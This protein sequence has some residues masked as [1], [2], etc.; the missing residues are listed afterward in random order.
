MLEKLR[1]VEERYLS[2]EG[3][4]ADPE[5][6][7]DWQKYSKLAKERSDLEPI[8]DKYRELLKLEEEAAE[9]RRLLADGDADLRQLAQE[10]I[11]DLEP[12]IAELERELKV[13]LVPRD[14]NDEKNIILEIRAG[15]G[16]EEA[17]LFGADLFRMYTKYA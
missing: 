3:R 5:V 17:A 15:T 8:V 7:G 13:L 1:Q 10:E 16:G 9:N 11:A 4:L 12:R 14:P 2:V 6:A